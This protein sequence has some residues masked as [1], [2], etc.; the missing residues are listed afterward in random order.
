MAQRALTPLLLALLATAQQVEAGDRL[1]ATGGVTEIEGSAGGGLTPWA[2]IAGLG[3]NDQIGASASCTRVRPQNFDLTSCGVA[4]GIDNRIELSLARQDFSL[5]DVAPG[6]SIYQTVVGAKV[7]VWGDALI[8]QDR[9]WPQVALGVQYKKNSDFNFIPRLIGAKSDHG[10]DAYLSAT[11]IYLAGPLGLT[12]LV[13]VTLRATRANQFGILGF[14]GDRDDGYSLVGEGSLA[15]FLADNVVL[16]GEYREK[17]N[18]LSAFREQDAYDAFLSWFATRYF[19][20][21]AA[22]VDLGNIATHPDQH[23]LYVSLQASF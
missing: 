9:W 10:I 6:A 14:G 12:W 16:G 21:T 17:P 5:G 20:V 15:V 3:T 8:D 22:Y 1:L 2:L 18:N 7:R 13:D 11:K 23:G 19:S 4:A